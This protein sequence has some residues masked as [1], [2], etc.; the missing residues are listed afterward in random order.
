MARGARRSETSGRQAPESTIYYKKDFWSKEN[1]KYAEPHFRMRKVARLIRSRARGKQCDLLDLGCGPAALAKILP[2][3]INYHGIDISI[4]EPAPNL[5]E[6]DI[7]EKPID[8]R[9]MKFDYVVAQGLFEYLGEHQSQKLA[10]IA[11][12]LTQQGKFILTYMNFDHRQRAIYWPY[13][14]VQR[15]TDFQRDLNRYF[16][17]EQRFAGSHNWN[18]GFPRRRVIR[19]PQE[20]L[21]IYVPVVSPRLAVDYFYVCTPRRQ[22]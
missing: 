11:A 12:T 2:P 19:M 10:E 9:G 8:F 15:P 17:V 21:N 18:H 5:I 7:L 13:S 14:N 1:I 4:P 6:A 3:N 22:P 16:K 20:H